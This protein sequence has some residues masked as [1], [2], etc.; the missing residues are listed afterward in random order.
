MNLVSQI[1]R[2]K[3]IISLAIGLF[4]SFFLFTRASSAQKG[5]ENEEQM[6]LFNE[7]SGGF[8]CQC[9]CGATIKSCPHISCGF[10]IPFK[11]ELTTFV[12]NGQT[13]EEIIEYFVKK[14]GEKLISAPP[15][16]GWYLV[17]YF[18][19]IIVVIL[20]GLLVKR[21]ISKWVTASDREKERREV[22]CKGP[23]QPDS[24]RYSSQFRKEFEEF[25]S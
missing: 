10:A 12:K 25:D 15:K 13:E 9:G 6:S 20:T 1:D 2:R 3:L 19:P 7:L 5:L 4:F 23:E 14:Y 17:G 16:R 24:E 11:K 18:F 22:E 21:I 8:A